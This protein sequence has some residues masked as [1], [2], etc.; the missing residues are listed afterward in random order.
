MFA[1]HRTSQSRW[2]R[3]R[4][5]RCAREHTNPG[6]GGTYEHQSTE[7][8]YSGGAKQYRWISLDVDIAWGFRTSRTNFQAIPRG[9]GRGSTQARQ[10][11]CEGPPVTSPIVEEIALLFALTDAVISIRPLWSLALECAGP[12]SSVFASPRC[13]VIPALPACFQSEL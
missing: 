11:S 10:R 6:Q 9:V 12:R 8:F 3:R 7:V 4:T 5:R 2:L 1:R 13:H